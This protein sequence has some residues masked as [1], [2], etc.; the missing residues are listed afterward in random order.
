MCP[1]MSKSKILKLVRSH[2]AYKQVRLSEKDMTITLG[3]DK[4]V[5]AVWQ[6]SDNEYIL[7]GYCVGS[8]DS[9]GRF[10]IERTALELEVKQKSSS[11]ARPPGS[12]RLS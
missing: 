9:A 4:K 5:I 11:T 2:P 6:D 7:K 1:K 8:E 12:S 10:T 3:A